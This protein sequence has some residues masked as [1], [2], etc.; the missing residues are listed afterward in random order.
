[1]LDWL[2]L[3]VAVSAMI[4]L[5]MVMSRLFGGPRNRDDD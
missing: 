2:I 4:V 5:M 3:G 1:M